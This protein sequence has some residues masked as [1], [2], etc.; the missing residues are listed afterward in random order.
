M[1]WHLFEPVAQWVRQS[2][3]LGGSFSSLEYGP[4][5]AAAIRR[6]VPPKPGRPLV[7]DDVIDSVMSWPD[8]LLN[9]VDATLYLREQ[10]ERRYDELDDLLQLGGSA[11]QVGPDHRQLVRRVDPTATSALMRAASPQDRASSELTA[12]WTAAYGRTTDPAKVWSHAIVAV[13]ELTIPLVVPTQSKPNLGH[14]LGQLDRQGNAWRLALQGHDGAQ[15][16]DPLVAMLRLMW[17]NPGRHGGA[18]ARAIELEEAQAVVHLAVTI[19]QWTRSGV[20]SKRL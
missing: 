15:S 6:H 20:L 3:G 1:P 2:F 9:V 17:P 5:L 19:V 11:W 13:E 8:G 7:V 16:V 14:V 4:R 18:Q 12:A 10:A